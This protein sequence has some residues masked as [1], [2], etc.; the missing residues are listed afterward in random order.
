MQKRDDSLDLYKA[1]RINPWVVVVLVALFGFLGSYLGQ[2]LQN[3]KNPNHALIRG[4][5]N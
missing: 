1:I 5:K 4:L 2:S 3:N